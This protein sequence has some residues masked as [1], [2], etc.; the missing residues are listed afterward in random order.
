[1]RRQKNLQR[2]V[3]CEP[4]FLDHRRLKETAFFDPV[5]FTVP[6]GCHVAKFEIGPDTGELA[7]VLRT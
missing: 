1:L 4:D 3:F 2:R 6:A 5:N 7:L